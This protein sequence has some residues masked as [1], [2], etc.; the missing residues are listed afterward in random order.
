MANRPS[1]K[2]KKIIYVNQTDH[3]KLVECGKLIQ[4]GQLKFFGYTT[5][6]FIYLEI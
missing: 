4:A 1:K 2:K 3:T 5:G 6:Q